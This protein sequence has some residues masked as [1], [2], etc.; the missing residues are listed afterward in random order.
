MMAFLRKQTED[1][2]WE[3]VKAAVPDG[4]AAFEAVAVG[5]PRSAG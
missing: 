5:R 1:V 4:A 2:S 3:Q